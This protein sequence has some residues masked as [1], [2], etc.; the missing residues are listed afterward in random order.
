[1]NNHHA[2]YED[3]VKGIS[4]YWAD[5][6]FSVMDPVTFTFD[7]VTSKSIGIIYS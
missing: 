7:P 3:L 5:K 2:K 1:M 4:S 6:L